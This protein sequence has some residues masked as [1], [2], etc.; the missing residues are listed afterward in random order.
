MQTS[1]L[2]SANLRPFINSNNSPIT[3]CAIY[4][5][6]RWYLVLN[7]DTRYQG[8]GQG[9]VIDR[10]QSPAHESGTLCLLCCELLKTRN[11]SKKVLKTHLFYQAAAPKDFLLLGAVYKLTSLILLLL[12]SKTFILLI[13]IR[14]QS[15]CTSLVQR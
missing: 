6:A 2:S 10:L 9:S 4:C 11:D 13:C 7:S 12:I 8:Q 3:S 1:S 14:L 5:S 15:F